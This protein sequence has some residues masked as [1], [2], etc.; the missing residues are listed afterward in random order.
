M[1]KNKM[2][3][4]RLS[5]EDRKLLEKDAKEEQRSI[6]NLLL[7]CWKQWRKDRKRR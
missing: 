2:T 3:S 4:L 6:A 1:G 7:W 5:E